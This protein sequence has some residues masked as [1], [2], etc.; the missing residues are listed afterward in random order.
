MSAGRGAQGQVGEIHGRGIDGVL[1]QAD[2]DHTGLPPPGR[3]RPPEE[4]N[5]T[6]AMV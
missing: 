1:E 5:S 4:G 6:K 3:R 2:G